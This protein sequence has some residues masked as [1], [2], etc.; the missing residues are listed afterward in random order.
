[1]LDDLQQVDVLGSWLAGESLVAAHLRNATRVRLRDL[2]PYVHADPWSEVLAG[3]VV[4]VVHPFAESITRQY[5]RRSGLFADPRVLPDFELK[6]LKAVQSIAGGSTG[7]A[8][9]F[10]AYQ[11]MRDEIAGT[12]FDIAILGCGAYGLPLAAE[13]KRLGKKAVQL[14]GACQILF[15]IKGKRWDDH[16]LISRLYNDHW[17]RPLASERPE[18]YLSIEGGCYW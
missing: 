16:E 13:V 7:F 18:N 10:D 17:V 6:T 4:L 5:G 2:E 1:M 8:T 12:S 14:G 3:K 11:S 15:G 9:W